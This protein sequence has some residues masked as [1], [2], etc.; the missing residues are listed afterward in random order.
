M[1]QRRCS[2]GFA[3]CWEVAVI[4]LDE[5]W[6]AQRRRTVKPGRNI[7]APLLSTLNPSES[8][9][10]GITYLAIP[11]VPTTSPAGASGVIPPGGGGPVGSEVDEDAVFARI[12]PKSSAFAP[13]LISEARA[14]F[15][16]FFSC[17]PAGWPTIVY[18]TF[19]WVSN[20]PSCLLAIR[21]PATSVLPVP[22]SVFLA[23]GNFTS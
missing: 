18:P 7:T 16:M 3:C 20:R 10:P 17:A 15:Q 13:I 23:V 1:S 6:N 5:N 8:R 9:N 19:A 4:L 21:Y 22:I 11:R 14:K 2:D 12:S